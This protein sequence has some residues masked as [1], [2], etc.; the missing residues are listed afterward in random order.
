MKTIFLLHCS[1]LMLESGDNIFLAA[2][3]SSLGFNMVYASDHES[4]LDYMTFL[5]SYDN[6]Q[7]NS[8]K[9]ENSDQG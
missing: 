9:E 3:L 6:A 1:L 5:E 7:P 8:E 4:F 2:F